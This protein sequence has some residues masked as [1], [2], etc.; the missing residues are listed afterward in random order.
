MIQDSLQI[1]AFQLLFLI[2]YDLFLKGETFFNWNRVYLLL[3]PLVSL[4]L[5]FIRVGIIQKNI[6]EAYSIQLPEIL[7]G[8]T[9][10]EQ[11]IN[12]GTLDTVVIQTQ[13]TSLWTI[14]YGIW[15]LG[16]LASFS[17]FVYKL[18]QIKSYN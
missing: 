18:F 8:G 10:P 1:L 15:I 3:T 5:P 14:L 16:M 7:L 13:Y 9:A 11:F 12:G 4:F 2:V 17:F 6:P